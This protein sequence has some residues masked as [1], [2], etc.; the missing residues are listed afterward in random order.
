MRTAG[1][2]RTKTGNTRSS[3]RSGASERAARF[4]TIL[5]YGVCVSESRDQAFRGAKEFLD[6]YYAKD[7]TRE[8]VE[9]WTACGPVDHCV[10]SIQEFVDAGVDHITIRPVGRDIVSI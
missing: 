3:A 4:Q 7:F 2:L 8:G 6:A 9:I 1:S 10:R 5:Y